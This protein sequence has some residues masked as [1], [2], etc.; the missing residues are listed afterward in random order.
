MLTL[1]KSKKIVVILLTLNKSKN[2][3]HFANLEQVIIISHLANFRQVKKHSSHFA[4]FWIGHNSFCYFEQ[5]KI[6]VKLLREKLDA[7]AWLF[8][9]PTPFSVIPQ[10]SVD[11]HQV[12]KPMPRQRS[13][14]HTLIWLTR[15]HAMPEVTWDIPREAEDFPR[16]D[17]HFKHAPLPTYLKLVGST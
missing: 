5:V 13:L 6:T 11:Y 16:G 2:S 4:E 8:F 10:S 12:F 7:Y 17:R 9:L 3:S 15:H 1:N 14:T